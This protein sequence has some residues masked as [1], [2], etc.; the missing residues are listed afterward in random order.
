MGT[1]LHLH[2]SPVIPSFVATR[3]RQLGRI[4]EFRSHNRRGLPGKGLEGLRGCQ[5]I[6]NNKVG[7][8]QAD[9][10]SAILINAKLLATKSTSA[11]GRR[12]ERRKRDRVIGRVGSWE[13]W[14][15]QRGGVISFSC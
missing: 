2:T 11:R 13:L 5:I 3:V 6:I 1:D 10:D 8:N 15:S 9:S 4:I 7:N 12:G 14:N